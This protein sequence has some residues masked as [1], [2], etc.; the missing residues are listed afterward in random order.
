MKITKQQ[1]R[2]IIKE[3]L[4]STLVEQAYNQEQVQQLG[5]IILNSIKAVLEGAGLSLDPS[6]FKISNPQKFNKAYKAYID[7]QNKATQ[8]GQSAGG[9]FQAASNILSKLDTSRQDPLATAL[10]GLQQQ[11]SKLPAP[12]RSQPVAGPR[13]VTKL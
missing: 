9:V 13:G 12:T 2:Q 10:Q 1:L 3:E 5:A 6:A 11:V 4:K 7:I 8:I